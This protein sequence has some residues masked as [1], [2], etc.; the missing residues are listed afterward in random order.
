MT[1][2]PGRY[3]KRIQIQSR[4]ITRSN[5]ED[6]LA[7]TTVASRW[8]SYEPVSG[9]EMMQSQQVQA[10][11]TVRWRMRYYSG[12]TTTHRILWG[13]R[14]FDINHIVDLERDDRMELLCR[15]AV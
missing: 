13:S 1:P 12:L 8:A 6:V 2:N 3:D 4:G 9:R 11:G 7:Y 14:V 15:E 10:E 5:G